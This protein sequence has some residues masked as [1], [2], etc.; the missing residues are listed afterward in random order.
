LVEQEYDLIQEIDA[1]L[2][3]KSLVIED[4]GLLDQGRLVEV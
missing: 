1:L 3:L 4:V 2:V